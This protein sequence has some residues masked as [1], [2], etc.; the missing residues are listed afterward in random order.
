[1]EMGL[2]DWSSSVDGKATHVYNTPGTF[3]ATFRVL[4]NK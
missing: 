4:D 1:M 2:L 3:I